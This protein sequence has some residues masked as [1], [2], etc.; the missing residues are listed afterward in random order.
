MVVI[1]PKIGLF[2]DLSFIVD[3]SCLPTVSTDS[4]GVSEVS[5][6]FR[7]DFDFII[8]FSDDVGA[9]SEVV[10]LEGEHV[11]LILPCLD[12]ERAPFLEAGYDAVDICVVALFSAWFSLSFYRCFSRFRIRCWLWCSIRA[13]GCEEESC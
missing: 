9:A 5:S 12:V 1:G 8:A 3:T 6:F 13:R 7:V 11:A 10:V 2:N 4:F